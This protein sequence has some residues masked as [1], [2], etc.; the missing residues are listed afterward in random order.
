[1]LEVASI[2]LSHIDSIGDPRLK[3]VMHDGLNYAISHPDEFTLICTHGK[4]AYKGQTPNMVAFSSLMAGTHAF[5]KKYE[6][7]VEQLIHDRSDEFRGTM[8]QY[9]KIFNKIEQKAR[10]SV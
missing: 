10:R 3:E 4:S 8:H 5:C 9:H 2:I 6:S 7:S 1:M